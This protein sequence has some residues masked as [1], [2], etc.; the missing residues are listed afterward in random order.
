MPCI[1]VLRH[2]QVKQ[3]RMLKVVTTWRYWACCLRGHGEALKH[4]PSSTNMARIWP[5]ASIAI[6][7]TSI[8]SQ[9]WWRVPHHHCR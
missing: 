8:I 7:I 3:V 6:S 2:R 4:F 1:A 9:G 5:G